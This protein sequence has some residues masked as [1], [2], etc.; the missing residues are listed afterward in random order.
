MALTRV[1]NV[2]TSSVS[3]GSSNTVVEADNDSWVVERIQV[4]DEEGNLGTT[5]DVTIRVA[6]NSITDQNVPLDLLTDDYESVPKWEF[7]WQSNRDLE[8]SYTNES[9]GSVTLD[10]TLWV[11]EAT[12]NETDMVPGSFVGE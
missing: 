7:V 12:G 1:F 9:G 2:E 11:R 5:S 4:R 8:F 10:F 3:N 6:G